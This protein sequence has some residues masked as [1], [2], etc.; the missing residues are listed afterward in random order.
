MLSDEN[1]KREIEVDLEEIKRVFFLVEEL[2][3]FF[4][5][6]MNYSKADEFAKKNYKELKTIYYD[7]LW[8]W[9]PNDV[10]KE[11]EER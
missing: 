3:T 11:L 4:H 1:M 6:P 2:H 7:I 8:E 5:Q 9:L 10:K